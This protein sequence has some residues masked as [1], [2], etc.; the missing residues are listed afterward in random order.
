MCACGVLC[1]QG[2]QAGAASLFCESAALFA[3]K[4]S[5]SPLQGA[6]Q[7]KVWGLGIGVRGFTYFFRDELLG[8]FFWPSFQGF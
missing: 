2:D 7:N 5:L 6:E 3:R 4:I 1:A 8:L